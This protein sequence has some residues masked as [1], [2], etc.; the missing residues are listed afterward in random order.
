V[1]SGATGRAAEYAADATAAAEDATA[2]DSS[3]RVGYM[4]AHAAEAMAPG[5]FA[6]GA[7]MAVSLA[8][9]PARHPHELTASRVAH[10]HASAAG[11]ARIR[12]LGL[13]PV[14]CQEPASA[15]AQLLSNPATGQGLPP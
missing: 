14:S 2:D 3:A 8:R 1:R 4:A 11:D 13:T 7:A 9:R 12:P 6:M 15:R 5:G 10:E